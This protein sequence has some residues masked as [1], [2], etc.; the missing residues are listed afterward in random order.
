MS[1]ATSH[2]HSRGRAPCRVTPAAR[3]RGGECS[4]LVTFGAAGAWD[5]RSCRRRCVLG[6]ADPAPL[7]TAD[8]NLDEVRMAPCTCSW[9]RHLPG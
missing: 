1:P 9:P 2:M 6:G 3:A 8:P 4:A 5:A 7:Q